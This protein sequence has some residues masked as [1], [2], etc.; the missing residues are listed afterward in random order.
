MFPPAGVSAAAD[1]VAVDA[2][3]AETTVSTTLEKRSPDALASATPE[4]SNEPCT[5]GLFFCETP[6]WD[7]V[8]V[9][10]LSGVW[11]RF[12]YCGKTSENH[13]W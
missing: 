9:C 4:L 8:I 6:G 2:S 13:G 7:W 10:N 11:E 1:A 3:T 5:P 12:N